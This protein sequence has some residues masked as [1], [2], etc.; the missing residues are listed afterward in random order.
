MKIN[1]EITKFFHLRLS[2]DQRDCLLYVKDLKIF[3]PV[4]SSKNCCD[5]QTLHN[6]YSDTIVTMTFFFVHNKC[7]EISCRPGADPVV[8][9]PTPST[10]LTVYPA[11]ECICISKIKLVRWT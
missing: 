3:L 9:T 1:R 8:Q 4:P 10:Y 11:Y 5:L 6:I 7:G 2:D